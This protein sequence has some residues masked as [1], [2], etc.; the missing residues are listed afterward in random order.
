MDSIF[1][2]EAKIMFT[3]SNRTKGKSTLGNIDIYPILKAEELLLD[4][5]RKNWLDQ[6]PDLTS[7]ASVKYQLYY[8][9]V[10][11]NFLEFS[12]NLPETKQGFYSH[13]G[14]FIDHGLE[15]TVRAMQLCQSYLHSDVE[16]EKS[17]EQRALWNYAVYTAALLLDVGKIAT[18]LIVTLRQHT[19]KLRIWNPS[20]GSMFKFASHYSYDFCAENWDELRRQITPLIA[21]QLMPE[22]GF[23]WLSSDKAILTAWFA[24]LQE[25]YRQ[26]TSWLSVIPLAD[27]EILDTYFDKYEKD[28]LEKSK[29]DKLAVFTDPAFAIKKTEMSKTPLAQTGGL[30]STGTE[31]MFSAEGAMNALE[32]KS[33]STAAGEAFLQWLKKNIANGNVSVNLPNSGVHIIG[34]GVLLL[35]KIFQDFVKENPIYHDWRA[36]KQQFEHLEIGRQAGEQQQVFRQYA[37]NSDFK[38]LT[39]VTL[40]TNMYVV[41]LHHQKMPTVNQSI[42]AVNLAQEALPRPQADNPNMPRPTQPN[43]PK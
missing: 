37:A 39:E 17:E 18:K 10:L 1:N 33:I 3:G 43:L 12:Q 24:L 23:S 25:N 29:I 30:F 2:T 36:V 31:G 35:T 5:R 11:R 26:V 22:I 7:V 34:E 13:F 32:K 6:L 21:K 15:R 20:E 9:P 42:V 8:L 40:V 4:E 19:K 16:S 27:A 38:L 14:G 41:F 28:L